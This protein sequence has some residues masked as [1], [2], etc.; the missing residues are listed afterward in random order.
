MAIRWAE[1]GEIRLCYEL[2]GRQGDSVLVLVHGLGASLA[3]FDPAMLE[4][5]V[6]GGFA[7]LCFDCRDSGRST[8][9]RDAPPFDLSAAG[10]GDRSVVRYTL[11][12]MADDT[13][14]LLGV[15]GLGPAHLVG[16]S[17]GGMIVQTCAVRHPEQVLSLC[18]IMSS[19]GGPG[20]GLPS[21]EAGA[22]LTRRP[23]RGRRGFVEQELENMA[24]TGSRSSELVD[25]AWRRARAERIYDHGVHPAGTGRQLMAV[26]ASGDRSASLSAVSVPT[27][28]VHGDADPL[29]DVSG[30][31]ATAAAVP[32][33]ELL[34]VPDMG[35]EL[36]PAAW[37]EVVA[38]IVGNARRG[39]QKAA[40]AKAGSA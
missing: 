22:V 9:L 24:V 40:G 18:S 39:E 7:V 34:V 3:G 5:F 10:R 6:E 1:V 33:A 35:H 17:M 38:A 20:V 27:L 26:I 16:I 4:M 31:R 25:L 14:G 8:V 2:R 11:D 37:P 21:P 13:A 36:P 23:A 30:G 32:G 28:V 29:I 15:L 12:E 19:T